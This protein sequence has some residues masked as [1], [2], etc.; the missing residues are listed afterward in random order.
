M[1]RILALDP[2]AKKRAAMEPLTYEQVAAVLHC[3]P[4]A[5]RLFWKAR[6]RSLFKSEQS[7]K[8]WNKRFAGREAFTALD[9]SGYRHGQILGR[10]YRAHRQIWLL[11]YGEWPPLQIDH[12][13]GA[14]S[15]NR[16]ANLRSVDQS[17]NMR[18]AKLPKRNTSGVVGVCWD[19]SRGQW[20]GQMQVKGKRVQIGRFDSFEDAVAAR[21]EAEKKHDFHKNHGRV[22]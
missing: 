16:V 22:A 8:T 12:V 9:S 4:E 7:F 18:N 10:H 21:K 3:D 11:H 13:N 14:P 20:L 19:A 2:A 17:V 6:P 15:D 1:T 5:G